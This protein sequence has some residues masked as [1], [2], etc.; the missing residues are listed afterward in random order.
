MIFV[1]GGT[2]LVGAHL[3]AELVLEN[4]PIR[5]SRRSNSN[6]DRVRRLFLQLGRTEAQ[7]Q[8][9]EWVELD[10]LDGPKMFDQLKG[11][12]EVYHCAAMV[13]FDS[14]DAKKMV[15]INISGTANVVNAALENKVRKF[16]HVSSTA[17]LGPAPN[18]LPVT[19]KT[20]WK[21][22]KRTSNYSI[23]KHFAEREVWRGAEEGL[24]V[25]VVNPCIV[26]GPGNW[27]SSSAQLFQTLWEGMKFFPSGANAF[28]DVRDVVEA[29][30]RLMKS[31]IENERFLVTG[32][33]LSYKQVFD[34]IAESL[35]VP[36]PSIAASRWML[37]IAWR[38]EWLQE[39]LTGKMAKIT[40]ENAHSAQQVRAFSNHKAKE[41]LSMEFRPVRAAI[42][43][44]ANY[45]KKE[46][47][48]NSTA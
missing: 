14:G 4:R 38:W 8:A 39:K 46:L 11:V 1:T 7:F 41:V 2:G 9:I 45:F 42:K 37:S 22:S 16:C 40:R 30:Q 24:S 35:N 12:E 27:G 20:K 3:L 15:Q 26:I 43:L 47:A 13:S 48:Q 10:L 19:E 29:M 21:T 34:W 44:T 33:N 18:G 25:V 36:A 17:A 6:L 28:V 23:S 31:D 32:E 5:A